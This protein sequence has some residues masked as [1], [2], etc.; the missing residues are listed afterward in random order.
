MRGLWQALTNSTEYGCTFLSCS[1]VHRSHTKVS[2][3]EK[4]SMNGGRR[5]S[6]IDNQNYL[7]LKVS[8]I[9][10]PGKIPGFWSSLITLGSISLSTLLELTRGAM[11]TL[12]ATLLNQ[13]INVT[14]LAVQCGRCVYMSRL[15]AKNQLPFIGKIGNL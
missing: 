10:H 3:N 11:V 13:K 12:E 7:K 8:Y 14:Y 9:T 2:I 6:F 5:P 4:L 15:T 1:S